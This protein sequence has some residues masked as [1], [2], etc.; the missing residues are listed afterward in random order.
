[1]TIWARFFQRAHKKPIIDRKKPIITSY[2]NPERYEY[3]SRYESQG[4]DL[5]GG[6]SDSNNRGFGGY[7]YGSGYGG[8]GYGNRNQDS[9]EA[10]FPRISH[11]GFWSQTE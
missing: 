5:A 3:S 2:N 7:G 1:M 4:R 9:N 10:Y 6:S 8:N 11:R